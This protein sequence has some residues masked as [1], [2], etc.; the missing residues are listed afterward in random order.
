MAKASVILATALVLGA[1]AL[2]VRALSANG[3]IAETTPGISLTDGDSGQ[4]VADRWKRRRVRRQVRR[5]G[6]CSRS[7][8]RRRC[9]FEKFY[10]RRCQYQYSRRKCYRIFERQASRYD[11][12]DVYD[13][14]NDSRVD[15]LGELILRSIF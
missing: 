3:N 13:D 11:R 4:L 1:T 6:F 10:A 5:Q 14:R 2:P 9:S 7:W 8:S 15:S 12:Y